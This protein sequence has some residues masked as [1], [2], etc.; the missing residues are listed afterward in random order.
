[1]IFRKFK[2]KISQNKFFWKY[3]HFLPKIYHNPNWKPKTIN[4]IFFEI[5]DQNKISSIMDF[6]FG[7]GDLLLEIFKK[8]KN[9]VKFFYGIDINSENRRKI[10][11][12]IHGPNTFFEK[13]IDDKLFKKINDSG[14]QKIDLI[15]FDRVLYIFSDNELDKLFKEITT[16]TSY[17]L[18]DD[19]T[20]TDVIK[21]PEYRH[22]N[23][24]KI[25]KEFNFK[26]E[27]IIDSINGQ[28]H[29]CI[30]KTLLFSRQRENI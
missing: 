23:W 29:N 30:S 7:S 16:L 3:R 4:N 17:I 26:P 1:M 22:R 20:E 21:D 19:F 5:I 8:R 11:K 6:G 25:L 9:N 27:I 28:P 10:K 2:R 18:I 12:I 13:K 15:V 14:I 24:I